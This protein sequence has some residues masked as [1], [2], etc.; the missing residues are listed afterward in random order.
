[1][2]EETITLTETELQARIDDAVKSATESL[3]S[4][5]NSEMAG[6]RT[7]YEKQL[8]EKDMSA[9]DL[10]KARAEEIAQANQQELSELRTFKKETIIKERLAKEGL[11]SYFL[12]DTRLLSAEEGELDKI[13]KV[14]KDDEI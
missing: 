4:K 5:H 6:I 8:K 1:M 13:I 12:H 14:V 10:A 3:I 7:K 9:E 11:P 2:A